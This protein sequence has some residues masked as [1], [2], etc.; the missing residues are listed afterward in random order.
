MKKYLYYFVILIGLTS[1]II[2]FSIDNI[3]YCTVKNISQHE[4][5]NITKILSIFVKSWYFKFN[6]ISSILIYVYMRRSKFSIYSLETKF[7]AFA[8][9]W[10]SFAFLSAAKE[11]GN[12]GNI[13]AGIIVLFH[14]LYIF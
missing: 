3:Y 5:Q 13:E 6:F 12:H 10:S 2:I 8:L 9:L 7:F 11:G 4:M 14:F 1:L